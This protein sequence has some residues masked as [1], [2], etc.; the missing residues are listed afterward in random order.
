MRDIKFRHFNTRLNEI[1]HSDKHDGEFHIN[2]KGVVYM[3][4]IPKS[5]SGITTEFYKS[6][7]VMQYTGI[8]DKNGVDIYEGDILLTDLSRPYLVVE[9]LGSSFVYRCHDSG[10]DYYDYMS[11]TYD[12]ETQ[13]KYCEVIGNIYQ[14]K[15]LLS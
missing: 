1:R 5:E 10:D 7:D 15:N 3:Y 4:A 13:D 6:Y 8:K 9:F 12:I 14:Y 2:A 11:S